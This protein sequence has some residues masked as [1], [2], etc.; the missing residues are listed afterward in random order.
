[1]AR[2]DGKLSEC[3]CFTWCMHNPDHVI[4]LSSSRSNS[5]V[6][7]PSQS[8]IHGGVKEGWIIDGRGGVGQSMSERADKLHVSP[9][10][11]GLPGP[12]IRAP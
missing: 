12:I 10:C 1:M 11:R 8:V 9:S 7:V 4:D 6:H 5:R 2:I 3:E